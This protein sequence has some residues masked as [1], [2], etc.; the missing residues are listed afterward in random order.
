MP[1]SKKLFSIL[2]IPLLAILLSIVAAKPTN[3]AEFHFQDY[4]CRDFFINQNLIGESFLSNE[5]Y[6][7]AEKLDI[8]THDFEVIEAFG[9]CFG[10]N[11]DI[12]ELL[13]KVSEN[14]YGC[15]N[16]DE[17]FAENLLCDMG[18]IPQNLPSY[19]YI[20]YVRTARD[21]MFDFSSSNNHYFRNY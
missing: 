9:D 1:I 6:K 5:I 12:D 7:I 14:Y 18:E 11:N 19:I 13:E 20:D 21:L 15:Y 3:A 4:E 2:A 17:D 8:S 16:S 10:Q